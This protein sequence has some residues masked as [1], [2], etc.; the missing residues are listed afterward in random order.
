MFLRSI[1]MKNDNDEDTN[2]DED[3]IQNGPLQQGLLYLSDK[4]KIYNKV[5][6]NLTL[7]EGM[8]DNEDTNF[9]R[10]YTSWLKNVSD[11]KNVMDASF[12]NNVNIG[13]R[14]IGNDMIDSYKK[15]NKATTLIHQNETDISKNINDYTPEYEKY[16]THKAEKNRMIGMLEDVV[17]K[18]KSVNIGYY[19]WLILAMSGVFI[20]I[21]QLRKSN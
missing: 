19:V 9:Q 17:L 2:H 1:F 16:N 13:A 20:V 10:L 7:I 15:I 4:D 3:S 6:D 21:N 11:N 14:L 18:N 12:N 5:H 8:S